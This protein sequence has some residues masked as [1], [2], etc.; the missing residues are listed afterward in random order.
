MSATLTLFKGQIWCHESSNPESFFRLQVSASVFI[1]AAWI[2]CSW[3][4]FCT[5]VSSVSR[6]ICS[7]KASSRSS[8]SPRRFFAANNSASAFTYSRSLSCESDS[9]AA[10]SWANKV[11]CSIKRLRSSSARTSSTKR[12]TPLRTLGSACSPQAFGIWPSRS[13]RRW[14]SALRRKTNWRGPF[15][16]RWKKAFS[17][18]TPSKVAIS[19]PS[20]EVKRSPLR[21]PL[22]CSQNC[23][24]CGRAFWTSTC[25]PLGPFS[26]WR[27]RLKPKYS[28]YCRPVP[29]PVLFLE[30]SSKSCSALLWIVQI[31]SRVR[32][33]AGTRKLGWELGWKPVWKLGGMF[34]W[35][36]SSSSAEGDTVPAGLGP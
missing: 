33:R 7:T 25:Q 31:A 10:S 28:R 5:A 35:T 9:L 20:I 27:M 21:I 34:S 2:S 16:R 24:A 11:C 22:W 30:N 36:L 29:S 26:G 32:C 8:F 17:S 4:S 12:C 13:H 3:L 1:S 19:C 18:R 23:T 14:F 15:R 6:A